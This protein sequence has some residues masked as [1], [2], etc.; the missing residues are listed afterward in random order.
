MWRE[1]SQNFAVF[2]FY[3]I[4]F[5]LGSFIWK[6]WRGID[7][8]E[9]FDEQT[10]ERREKERNGKKKE[11]NKTRKQKKEKDNKNKKEKERKDK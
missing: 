7:R 4:Q 11:K 8:I 5:L 6:I 1:E 10:K 3:S 9:R 2:L